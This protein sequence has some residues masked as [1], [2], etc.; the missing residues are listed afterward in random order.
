MSE[1]IL[2]NKPL[3]A[4]ALDNHCGINADE[5]T[6]F[7]DANPSTLHPYRPYLYG[8]NL[9]AT[10]ESILCQMAP[11]PVSR[12][13]TNMSLS[14]GADNT[15]ALAEISAKLQEYNIGM[16]GAS[17]SFYASRV[18]G[19]GGAVK[20]YQVALM[21]FRDAVK[22]NPAAKAA[23]KQKAH[24]AFNR[25][26]RGFRT[27]LSIVT[28][29]SRALSRRGTPL[30]N[31]TR[32]INI[33]RS[34]RNIVKL[35]VTSQVQASNLVKF[36]KQA[37]FLGNGLAV[38]DFT[39]RIGGIHNSYQA[40]GNWERDM[41]IES[42]SFVTS[43]IAGSLAVSAGGTAL[44]FLLVATPIGWVGLIIGGIAVVGAAAATSIGV[45]SIVKE[46]SGSWYDE[47][48]AWISN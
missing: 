1:I 9:S 8:Q 3:R 20:S 38:I 34:S 47:I 19:F 10:E 21:E 30:T 26:Q 37:K 23:A 29:R 33:A 48:M 44:T 18:E 11:L 24:A 13:L 14:F 45:N 31:P 41:F 39:S 17:T 27:E 7:G 25:M 42:S 2:C 35:N 16:M 6:G 46:N 43:A 15:L 5:L 32:G 22:T 40:G 4:D 36:G 12:E 28:R